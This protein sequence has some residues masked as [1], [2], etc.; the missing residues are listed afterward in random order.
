[1]PLFAR[2]QKGF[3]LVELLIVVLIAAV[4]LYLVAQMAGSFGLRKKGL[5]DSNLSLSNLTV[6]LERLRADIKLARDVSVSGNVLTLEYGELDPST[7]ATQRKQVTYTWVAPTLTR[8]FVILGSSAAA[9]TQTF[10]GISDVRWCLDDSGAACTGIKFP[11]IGSSFKRLMVEF[12]YKT[13]TNQTQT[14]PFVAE[15]DNVPFDCRMSSPLLSV[16][17]S[18]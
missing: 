2:N 11:R 16:V 17:G 6:P 3:T 10:S 4:P 15:L 9:A 8:S 5:E 18:Q 1:M 12:D 14:L 7:F 13:A